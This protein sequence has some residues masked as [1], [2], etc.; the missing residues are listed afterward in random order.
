M[1][2]HIEMAKQ[3]V[4]KH[5]GDLNSLEAQREISRYC[6]GLGSSEFGLWLTAISEA[7]KQ[8]LKKDRG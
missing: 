5:S 2:N 3:I 1:N 4:S 6:R 7:F 8:H